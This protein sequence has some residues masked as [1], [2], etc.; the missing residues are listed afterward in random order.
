MLLILISCNN[1]NNK[2]DKLEM[3][4]SRGG[5][6]YVAG[7]SSPSIADLVCYTEVSQCGM[8]GVPLKLGSNTNIWLNKMKELP[9]H[10]DVHVSLL[11]LKEIV[12]NN[13]I[14]L[15]EMKTKL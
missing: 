12:S 6:G 10:D 9:H 13:G 11:K 7:T 15:N 1:M 5:T 3:Y 4:L 14:D 8:L 2:L